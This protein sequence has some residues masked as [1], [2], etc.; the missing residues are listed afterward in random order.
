MANSKGG[1]FTKAQLAKLR[2]EY[3]KVKTVPTEA[4]DSWHK[5]FSEL[6]DGALRQL[7]EANIKFLSGIAQND[8]TRRNVSYINWTAQIAYRL[9]QGQSAEDARAALQLSKTDF[10]NYRPRKEVT[11]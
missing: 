9:Q 2:Q 4:L 10:D 5:V 3:A 11:A 7:A 6:T 8:C 1:L